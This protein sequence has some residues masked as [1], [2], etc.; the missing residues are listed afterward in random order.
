MAAARAASVKL[1]RGFAELLL[2]AID[3][4]DPRAAAHSHRVGCLSRAVA[5]RLGEKGAPLDAIELAGVL[6]NVGKLFVPA[7]LLTKSEALEAMERRQFEEGSSRWLDL[8]R[9][10]PCELPLEEILHSAYGLMQGNR[11]PAHPGAFIIAACNMAVALTSAR[12]YRPAYPAAEAMQILSQ[13]GIAFPVPVLTALADALAKETWVD[14][15]A[16]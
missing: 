10:I 4:R 12:A 6:L 9:R 16:K 14:T 2:L 13:C 8:L 1:Y 11:G 3:Q 7:A 5:A 15:A